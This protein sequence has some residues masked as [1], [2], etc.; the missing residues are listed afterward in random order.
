[1]AGPPSSPAPCCV[2][3]GSHP[4]IRRL[5]MNDWANFP[6]GASKKPTKRKHSTRHERQQPDHHPFQYRIVARIS[7]LL[8]VAPAPPPA[9]AA[10]WRVHGRP[11]SPAAPA[12]GRCPSVSGHGWRSVGISSCG[13]CMDG[14]RDAKEGRKN[15][16][17]TL[18]R[19]CSGQL[20]AS[21]LGVAQRTRIDTTIR[22]R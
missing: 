18:H 1:M 17:V 10:R 14:A 15:R 6:T 19:A 12:L 8:P 4:K 11:P 3:S 7:P 20:D 22:P 21:S 5:L 16:F 13:P 2:T 9:R